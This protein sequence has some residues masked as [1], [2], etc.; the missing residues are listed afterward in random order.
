MFPPP[1]GPR[2]RLQL[3][4]QPSAAPPA[5]KVA[6]PSV[7]S[8]AVPPSMPSKAPIATSEAP[9]TPSKAATS[10]LY[11]WTPGKKTPASPSP[12][13][14]SARAVNL[15][16]AQEPRILKFEH[17]SAWPLPRKAKTFIKNLTRPQ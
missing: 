4:R 16:L 10:P 11:A 1:T 7:A 17:V 9:V 15:L 8:K 2:I 13:I 3:D 5:T 12:K 6:K 14:G